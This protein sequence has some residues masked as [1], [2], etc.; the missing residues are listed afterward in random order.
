MLS[1][2]GSGK[3][4]IGN[5]DI[6]DYRGTQVKRTTVTAIECISV[7][8]QVSEPDDHLASHYSSE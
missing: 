5:D 3:V 8:G 1:M 7:D 2:L 6:W 4:L